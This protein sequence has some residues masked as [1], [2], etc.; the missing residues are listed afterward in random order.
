[1]YGTLLTTMHPTNNSKS[2]VH[3]IDYHKLITIITNCN[4]KYN[5][6]NNNT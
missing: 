5:K 6:I 3:N 4:T 2:I 1:M